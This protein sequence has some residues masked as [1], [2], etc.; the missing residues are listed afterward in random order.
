[1][2]IKRILGSLMICIC[3]LLGLFTLNSNRRL[4]NN[5]PPASADGEDQGLS[6]MGEMG[7]PMLYPADPQ[8]AKA[9]TRSIVGQ[10]N[11]FKKDDYRQASDYQSGI[12]RRNYFDSGRFRAMIRLRYP[13]FAS[14]KSVTF[15]Q[16]KSAS[17]ERLVFVPVAVTGTNGNVVSATY[18]MV[19]QGGVYLVAGVEGGF[20]HPDPVPADPS[21]S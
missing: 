8:I 11:A 18:V 2:N 4:L 14:Y 3:V 20:E 5:V 12:L 7:G 13:E 16:I 1:M 19:L 10:L 15:G 6:G 21:F 9:A 17:K